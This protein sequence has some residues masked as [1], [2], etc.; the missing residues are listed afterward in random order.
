MGDDM[1]ARQQQTTTTQRVVQVAQREGETDAEALGRAAL[2]P[3]IHAGLTLAEYHKSL[4]VS[5]VG[6]MTQA[7][8]DQM[9]ALRQGDLSRIE[10]I[11]ICQAHSLDGMFN[12]LVAWAHRSERLNQLEILLRLG[13]KSQAQCRATL[14]TLAEIRNPPQV[15][16][17]RQANIANGPQQVNNGVA[18]PA[19]PAAVS[20]VGETG[21]AP[22]ELLTRQADGTQL[23][24]GTA[25]ATGRSDPALAAVAA[26]DGTEDGKR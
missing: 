14:Q 15:A 13:L 22:N 20:R 1:A 3:E 23:D 9:Q 12:N 6:D 18:E 7:L 5:N 17:V 8:R 25:A 24:L 2:M 21:N 4:E 19:R 26:V 16:F 10:D 11:L